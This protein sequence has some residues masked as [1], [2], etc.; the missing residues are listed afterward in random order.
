MYYGGYA[1]IDKYDKATNDLYLK[2]PNK[3]IN[4]Y[5]AKDYLKSLFSLSDTTVFEQVAKEVRDI[6]TLTPIN[7]MDSKIKEIS[8]LFDS[9]LDDFTY[10]ALRLEQEFRNIMDCIF[11][12]VFNDVALE[13][14]LKNGRSDTV[15]IVKSRTF[16]IEYK[17]D[18]ENKEKKEPSN[19]APLNEA[20]LSKAPLNEAPSNE[21]PSNKAPLNE[22]PSNKAPSKKA[23]SNK[24]PSNKALEQIKEKE[25]YAKYLKTKTPVLLFGITLKT[26]KNSTNKNIDI[27]YDVMN[28]NK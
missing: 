10:D 11:K 17:V 4:K 14:H 15:I 1:T 7:E 25:Y 2:I 12:I 6:M 9:L 23:P 5:L 20:P 3:S 24:A 27:Q 16:I 28:N 13:L 21:A 8:K 18:N 22:A 26:N 19:E